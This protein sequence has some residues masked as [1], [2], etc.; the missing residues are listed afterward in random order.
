MNCLACKKGCQ[1]LPVL[2]DPEK[3]EW[4]CAGFHLS[5]PMDQEAFEH[6]AARRMKKSA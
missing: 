6:F 1:P 2:V 5:Y 4:Y 3:S